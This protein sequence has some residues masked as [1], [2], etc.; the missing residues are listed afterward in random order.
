MIIGSLMMKG[1]H[2]QTNQLRDINWGPLDH[3]S[4]VPQLMLCIYCVCVCV[5]KD[6][7]KVMMIIVNGS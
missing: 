2:G 7:K 4:H 1:D 6:K 5:F 3:A